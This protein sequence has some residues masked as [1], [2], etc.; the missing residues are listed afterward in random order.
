[1]AGWLFRWV[2]Y[3]GGQHLLQLAMLLHHQI[4][5]GVARVP[6][7]LNLRELAP[8]Q[9][10]NANPKGSIQ[11]SLPLKLLLLWNVDPTSFKELDDPICVV[12]A[13]STKLGR[14]LQRRRSLDETAL[15]RECTQ[16]DRIFVCG[17]K[18]VYI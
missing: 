13:D 3:S 2:G 12:V 5:R 14:C 16:E 8:S 10:H 17:K 4:E 11:D 7:S 6:L 15:T 1:M 18:T 9:G